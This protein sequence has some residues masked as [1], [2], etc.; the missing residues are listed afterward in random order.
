MNETN[1]RITPE[2]DAAAAPDNQAAPVAQ[3][4]GRG[5]GRPFSKGVSGNPA[6]KPRGTPNKATRLVQ[7]LLKERGKALAE[8]LTERALILRTAR[9]LARMDSR[10]PCDSEEISFRLRL[11]ALEKRLPGSDR[12]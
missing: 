9:S 10:A 8:R 11:A 6:G 1:G 5:F 12:S 2:S 4:R 7:L 3:G